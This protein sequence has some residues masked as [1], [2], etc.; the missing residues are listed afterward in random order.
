MICLYPWIVW[1]DA[2]QIPAFDSHEKPRG[3]W[4]GQEMPSLIYLSL[5]MS[6]AFF[7][8]HFCHVT[9]IW[10]HDINLTTD[11][12]DEAN[13]NAIPF[14]K[15]LQ[16]LDGIGECFPS[17]P[18]ARQVIP[19]PNQCNRG[20]LTLRVPQSCPL[21]SCRKLPSHR[22]RVKLAPLTMLGWS[23][24]KPNSSSAFLAA[25]PSS[26]SW[27]KAICEKRWVDETR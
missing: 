17:G 27:S 9:H 24:G 5:P 10:P 15:R 25:A 1:V 19:C 2:F 13:G 22:R 7:T 6:Y 8:M 23:P 16:M 21:R 14:A 3:W 18:L 4:Y 11:H 12:I 26:H 20:V